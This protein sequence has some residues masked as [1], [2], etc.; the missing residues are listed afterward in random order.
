MNKDVLAGMLHSVGNPLK[1]ALKED[2]KIVFVNVV[3]SYQSGLVRPS[4]DQDFY[5]VVRKP[6]HHYFALRHTSPYFSRHVNKDNY[7]F[8]IVDYGM[9]I[10]SC[11]ESR[12]N[13]YV[14]LIGDTL[15]STIDVN[16][17]RAF[18]LHKFVKPKL[19]VQALSQGFNNY[20]ELFKNQKFTPQKYNKWTLHALYYQLLGYHF[21][22]NEKDETTPRLLDFYGND[23]AKSLYQHYEVFQNLPEY[24][25]LY[26]ADK[27][28]ELYASLKLAI[29][30]D[31][32]AGTYK[33]LYRTL[34]DLAD[35]RWNAWENDNSYEE[36]LNQFTG[37]FMRWM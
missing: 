18:Y 7:D 24:V 22:F 3:G 28:D 29:D 11:A 33:S 1:N 32:V 4:S 5:V 17:H 30:I 20:K 6:L 35:E 15:Y 37:Y 19:A 34:R 12:L 9:F 2:E 16:L 31:E 14:G 26:K 13:A 21:L 25:A 27:H 10:M 36:R 8:T 23:G